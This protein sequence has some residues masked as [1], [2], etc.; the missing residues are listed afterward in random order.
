MRRKMESSR[1]R[2]RKRDADESSP[3]TTQMAFSPAA[4]YCRELGQ[5]AGDRA[6]LGV[7][8]E[9]ASVG[10][11]IADEQKAAAPE[12]SRSDATPMDPSRPIL[13]FCG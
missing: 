3:V 6:L 1:K 2:D 12:R 5:G 11:E 13:L 8:M 10:V 7:L 9:Y 4:Q